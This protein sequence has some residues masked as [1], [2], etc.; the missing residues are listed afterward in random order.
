VRE[1]AEGE[2]ALELG[3]RADA[4]RG[5]VAGVRRISLLIA[6]ALVRTGAGKEEKAGTPGLMPLEIPASLLAGVRDSNK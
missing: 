3:G 4:P 2:V 1:N 5:A 6:S